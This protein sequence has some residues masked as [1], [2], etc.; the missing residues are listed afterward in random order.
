[1]EYNMKVRD[2]QDRINW[3]ALH[4]SIRFDE[5]N[6]LQKEALLIMQPILEI[7]DINYLVYNDGATMKANENR[8]YGE[9]VYDHYVMIPTSIAFCNNLNK[10]LNSGDK[11]IINVGQDICSYDTKKKKRPMNEGTVIFSSGTDWITY[12]TSQNNIQV[13]EDLMKWNK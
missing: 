8:N 9:V 10:L 7:Y 6:V 5:L 12:N 4:S 11:H 13:T 1:M 3:I 2:I